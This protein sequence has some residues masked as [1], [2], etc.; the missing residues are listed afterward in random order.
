MDAESGVWC[1]RTT[2]V[3]EVNDEARPSVTQIVNSAVAQCYAETSGSEYDMALWL[4]DWTLDQLDTTIRS[5]G[6]PPR[7]AL[8]AG[9]EPARATS[10]STRSS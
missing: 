10:A 5:T 4:H 3:V 7:A 8:R 6:A 9:R 1:L 2:A